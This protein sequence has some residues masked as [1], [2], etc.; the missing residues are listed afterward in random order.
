MAATTFPA[1][2]AVPRRSLRSLVELFAKEAKYEILKNIRIPIYAAST[3]VFPLM[4]YVLFGIVLAPGNPVN[5]SQDA[6]YLLATMGTF[7]VMGAALF[8]FAVSLAMERG[9]GWLQVKRA[10]PM[11]L[12]AY[13]TAKLVSAMLF[14]AVIG[15]LLLAIGFAFAHVRVTPIQAIELIGVLV[16]AAIPFG[17]MGLALGYIAKPNSA[18]AVVN[19]IY[20]PLS[21]CS[22]LWIPIFLLPKFVQSMAHA[23]P[24]FHISQMVLRVLGMSRETGTN[25][26]HLQ[27]LA[28]F[29]LL[30]LGIAVVLYRRDEG[31]LYG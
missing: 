28:G 5:R 3:V 14:S 30:F 7:G 22:G 15:V 10:S 13:F 18:P 19:L 2:V 9:Q 24:P 29:T 8:G 6:T 4:F 12:A 27:A 16:L 23:L 20:L 17:A 1:Q 25:W 31:Q 26:G 21:F 11:P